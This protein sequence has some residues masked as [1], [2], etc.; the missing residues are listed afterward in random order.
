MFDAFCT[1]HYWLHL[2]ILQKKEKKKS[3]CYRLSSASEYST[4]T[5]SKYGLESPVMTCLWPRFWIDNPLIYEL[6]SF[7]MNLE[8]IFYFPIMFSSGNHFCHLVIVFIRLFD[9][10]NW[11]LLNV[12]SM[13]LLNHHTNA[14][15]GEHPKKS[16]H[17]G[18]VYNIF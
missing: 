17:I 10:D 18:S 5:R 8:G 4:G 6:Y 16:F 3:Q 2:Q 12:F 14:F 1:L 11:I 9:L 15:C 13:L 7:F